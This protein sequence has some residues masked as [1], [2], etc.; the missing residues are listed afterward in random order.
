MTIV[1]KSERN[2]KFQ[3]KTDLLWILLKKWEM[4]T[5]TNEMR[6]F[7]SMVLECGKL[8]CGKLGCVQIRK[9]TEKEREEMAFD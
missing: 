1:H 7:H 9:K 6:L 4:Q 5:K 8:P 3:Q 2:E